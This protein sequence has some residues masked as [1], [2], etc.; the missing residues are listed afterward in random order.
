M[1]YI[2][3]YDSLGFLK[4]LTDVV[5]YSDANFEKWQ[6]IAFSSF[7]AISLAYQQESKINTY[8]SEFLMQE[9]H[10]IKVTRKWMWKW[11]NK[12]WMS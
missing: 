9:T 6:T 2:K 10:I 8:L 12:L 5:R 7:G 1:H 4:Y 11:L 3:S